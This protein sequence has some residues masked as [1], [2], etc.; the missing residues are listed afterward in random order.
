MRWLA[1][2]LAAA[3]LVWAGN[4]VSALAMAAASHPP[5]ISITAG[6]GL[7]YPG[8]PA[9]TETASIASHGGRLAM[10]VAALTPRRPDSSSLCTA[11]DPAQDL[12]VSVSADSQLLYRGALSLLARQHG[13]RETALEVPAGATNLTIQVGL[14]AGAGD[15]YMGCR[16][17]ASLTWVSI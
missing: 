16:S 13:E 1:L 2:P 17:S 6:G 15:A 8:G 12:D 11:L 7:L 14:D 3:G 4:S 9:V 10:Y 5:R